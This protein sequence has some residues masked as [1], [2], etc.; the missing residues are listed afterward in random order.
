MFV[1][2]LV[3]LTADGLYLMFYIYWY[4]SRSFSRSSRPAVFTTPMVESHR[5]VQSLSADRPAF[6]LGVKVV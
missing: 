4:H 3:I 5:R 1:L 6:V 2:L